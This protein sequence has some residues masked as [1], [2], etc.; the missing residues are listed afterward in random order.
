V[1]I[2][3]PATAAAAAAAAA[4]TATA[5]AATRYP[6]IFVNNHVVISA[7]DMWRFMKEVRM[8]TAPIDDCKR[9]YMRRAAAERGGLFDTMTTVLVDSHSALWALHN[10]ESIKS[11]YPYAIIDG[12]PVI[13]A[14][15]LFHLMQESSQSG[16][17]IDDAKHEYVR[18]SMADRGEHH[19]P[20]SFIMVDNLS[21]LGRLLDQSINARLTQ[22]IQLMCDSIRHEAATRSINNDALCSIFDRLFQ[23]N[24][25]LRGCNRKA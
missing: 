12:A 5:A 25:E 14:E 16:C 13:P 21:T 7:S 6:Y 17:S 15:K 10:A 3:P 22:N 1:V 11:N 2:A 24:G 20:T 9:E 4:A 8:T 18:R 19:V 23:I